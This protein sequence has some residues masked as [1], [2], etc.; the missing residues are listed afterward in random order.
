MGP[1]SQHKAAFY[2]Q[3]ADSKHSWSCAATLTQDFPYREF[4][5]KSIDFAE[6]AT[7]NRKVCG[8]NFY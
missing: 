5:K 3:L 6:N 4:T 2:P 7:Y 8:C 1:E